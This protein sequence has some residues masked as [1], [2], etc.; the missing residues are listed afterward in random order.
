MLTADQIVHNAGTAAYACVAQAS[1][2]FAAFL[3]FLCG[4]ESAAGLALVA[5]S[6]LLA[7]IYMFSVLFRNDGLRNY[8]KVEL[9]ELIV[10]CILI[11]MIVAGVH[12]AADLKFSY[13]VPGGAASG[14]PQD[15]TIYKMS[16]S[17][18][19]ETD[20]AMAQ[21]LELNYVMGAYL[22]TMAS[23]TPYA[24]S[25]G[26]GIV[27]APLAG[28]ASPFK[29]LIYNMSTALAVAFII[30]YAQLVVYLFAL[31]G[32]LHYY[33]PLGIILRSFTPTRKVG[34]ALIGIGLTFVFLFPVLYSFNY[35][36]FYNSDAGPMVTFSSFLKQQMTWEQGK[37]SMLDRFRAFNKEKYSGGFMD[38]VSEGLSGI[39]KMLTN[40]IGGFFTLMMVLPLSV[41][42]R[43]FALGFILPA[44]NTLLLIQS[45]KYLS[46]TIGE[47]VDISPLTR[48]I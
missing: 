10:T 3:Q 6:T 2:P 17:F 15:M 32:S 29:Q 35:L 4:W 9:S 41:V 19:L 27:A 31:A 45:A 18:F 21:W 5:S 48:L 44:F 33:I 1:G 22:D 23:A 14:I 20:K 28:L 16:E 30:N 46:R 11:A 13:I 42:G 7:M 40:V 43:A 8:V 37:E 12:A 26:I 24:R 25:L 47:E 39:G 38:F 36:M 34:G